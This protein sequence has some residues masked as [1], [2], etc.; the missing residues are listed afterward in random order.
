MNKKFKNHFVV[1]TGTSVQFV[2]CLDLTI[3]YLVYLCVYTLLIPFVSSYLY[4][5]VSFCSGLWCDPSCKNFHTI[6]CAE[7]NDRTKE[8]IKPLIMMRLL[9]TAPHV[10]ALS[11]SVG[12]HSA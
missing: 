3:F 2:R 10:Q 6:P 8:R 4:I 1:K 9:A 7:D 11:N 12:P 5:L